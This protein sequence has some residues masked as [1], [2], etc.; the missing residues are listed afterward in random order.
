MTEPQFFQRSGPFSLQ[1]VLS[2]VEG[3]L[4]SDVA[5]DALDAQMFTNIAALDL[6]SPADVS[7]FENR[8]YLDQFAVTKA[9]ACLIAARDKA[10][11]P[12]G[13]VGIVVRKPST[14]FSK[15]IAAFY[16]DG[17]RPVGICAAGVISPAAHVDPTA[18]LEHGVSVEPGAV[19]GAAARIGAGT[20]I[21]ATAVIGPGVSIGRDC[22]IGPAAV[23]RYALIGN[24]VIIHPGAKI[25]QDGFG[26]TSSARGHEKVPQIG[27]VVIQDKVEIGANTTIDR[28]AVRDTIIGEGTKID[29][30]VQIGHNVVMGRHCMIVGQVG[31]AGSAT[32][33][34]FVAVAG[35]AGVAG[36]CTVGSGAQIAGGSAVRDD[37]PAGQSWIGYPAQPV[38]TWMRAQ[39]WLQALMKKDGLATTAADEHTD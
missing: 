5:A 21:C 3:T 13:V 9:G 34:D 16:P 4:A 37:V 19:I 26:Y 14:A 23:V 18:M 2:F 38:R 12:A 20:T 8:K 32:L 1:Q 31:I 27:R 24:Q 29:N 6:A 11:L 36:H 22:Y 39:R 35:Q 17:V 10:V 28:G 25:G 30:Q 15:L 33:G 7:F